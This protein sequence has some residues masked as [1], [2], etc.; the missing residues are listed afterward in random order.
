MP[1]VE[2]IQQDKPDEQLDYHMGQGWPSSEMHQSHSSGTHTPAALGPW[3]G[4]WA[5]RDRPATI[6]PSYAE[7]SP[8]FKWINSNDKK[9]KA[10]LPALLLSP[11]STL[12]SLHSEEHTP[13]STL[14]TL[15]FI[16]LLRLGANSVLLQKG[17]SGYSK[18]Y[19]SFST[20]YPCKWCQRQH[21][22]RE[23]RGLR[24]CRRRNRSWE[25]AAVLETPCKLLSTSSRI[26]ADA[27]CSSLGATPNSLLTDRNVLCHK[28]LPGG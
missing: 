4:C 19:S 20:T 11:F 3:C 18:R 1:T 13:R 17:G 6:P 21:F 24:M 28:T 12:C 2:M 15:V 23:D 16:E 27:T 26:C 9:H 22:S 10:L 7:T 5:R 8:P 25:E 14:H